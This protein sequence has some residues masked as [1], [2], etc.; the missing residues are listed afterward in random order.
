MANGLQ[1]HARQ[2]QRDHTK[3]LYL[4]KEEK[5]KKN[6]SIHSHPLLVNFCHLGISPSHFQ[7]THV[8][9]LSKMESCA[10]ILK[11]SGNV[12]LQNK[13]QEGGCA[14]TL[15]RGQEQQTQW[16]HQSK[17]EAAIKAVTQLQA[18][19]T[20]QATTQVRKQSVCT[21]LG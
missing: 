10:H 19:G 15:K 4:Q 7:G 18:Y 21:D 8:W 20:E 1:S 16:K 14:Q 6:L 13:K 9:V 2:F 11:V 5:E 3:I 17:A 12:E